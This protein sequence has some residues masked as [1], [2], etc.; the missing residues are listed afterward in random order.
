MIMIQWCT[1]IRDYANV[2]DISNAHIKSLKYLISNE[3]SQ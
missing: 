3:S 2:E 1:C